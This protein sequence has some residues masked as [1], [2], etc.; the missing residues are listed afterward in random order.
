MSGRRPVGNMKNEQISVQQFGALAYLFTIGS[1]ILIVPATLSAA[2]QDAWLAALL[3]LAVGLLLVCLYCA[4]GRRFPE[5]NLTAYS[6]SIFGTWAGRA[7]SLLFFTYALILGSL[8][9]R[10]I[11]DFITTEM[12]PETPIEAIHALMLL[13]VIFAIRLNF[14]ALGRAA[15]IFFFPVTGIFFLTTVLIL[16]HTEVHHLLPIFEGGIKPI[17]RGSISFIGLPF[18]ELVLFV[19]LFPYVNRPKAVRKGFLIGTGLAGFWLF[20]ATL[21]SLI[22]LSTVITELTIYPT[23]YVVKKI[24]VA[25]FIQRVESTLAVL[26][27]ISIFFKLAICMYTALLTLGQAF[28]LKKPRSLAI[29]L[30]MI[31]FILSIVAYPNV[32]YFR[33]FAFTIWPFYAATFGLLLPLV[34]FVGSAFRRRSPKGTPSKKPYTRG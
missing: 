28:R 29:P 14:E 8:V 3:G 13:V 12:M 34:L 17:I 24:N 31:M 5:S 30:A 32:A 15:E 18:L 22:G 23:Y 25:D 26:W 10:N 4:L 11:G 1:S 7:V 6:E 27:F 21:V 16:P 19:V 9:L 20:L 2:R 33:E